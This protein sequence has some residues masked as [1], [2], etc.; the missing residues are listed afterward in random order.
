[1]QKFRIESS[2]ALRRIFFLIFKIYIFYKDFNAIF[3]ETK[4]FFLMPTLLQI[5]KVKKIPTLRHS[6]YE[7]LRMTVK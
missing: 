3:Y 7:A 6:Q 5:F 1:M 2:M 4:L